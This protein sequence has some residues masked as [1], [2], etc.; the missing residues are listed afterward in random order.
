MKK[1]ELYRICK[2]TD[3]GKG[4]WSWMFDETQDMED[5][6]CVENMSTGEIFIAIKI[7]KEEAD[8]CV[9]INPKTIYTE[10]GIWKLWHDG[11][12]YIINREGDRV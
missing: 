7:S 5:V 1:V 2:L 8:K 10:K 9:K 11:W 4:V 3:A 12:N 6:R